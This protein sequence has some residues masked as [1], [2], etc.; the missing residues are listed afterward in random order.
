MAS[1]ASL[2]LGFTHLLLWWKTSR[3]VVYLLSAVMAFSASA[4]AMIEL[5]QMKSQSIDT[6]ATLLQWQNLAVYVL[7]LSMV[8]VL[9]ILLGTARRWL[10]IV[11]TLAWSVAIVINFNSP[12]S[13][14][15]SDIEGLR[16]IMVFG[17]DFFVQAYGPTHPWKLMV[18]IASFVILIYF[19]DAS[20]AAW[21]KGEGRRALIVGGG[22]T[23]FILFGGIHAGLVDAA[24]IASPY[25]ISFGFLAVVIAM[26]YELVS[27]AVEKTRYA[28]RVAADEERWA[29]LMENI[30]LAVIG[31][32]L[33]GRITYANPFISRLL[34]YP[35]S[36]LVGYPVVQL[37]HSDQ[38]SEFSKRLSGLPE[39]GPRDH[40]EWSLVDRTGKDHL[41]AWSSVPQKADDGR[42]IGVLSVGADI[43]QQRKA[44]TELSRSQYEMERMSRASLLGEL[45]S[46][47][48]H[49]LNQPLAAILSNTQAA[50]RLL[51]KEPLDTD[52]L[53]EI[54]DDI[55]RDNKRASDVIN[56]MRAML[57][58]DEPKRDRISLNRLIRETV[59]LVRA[60]FDRNGIMIE[61][62][63]ADGLPEVVAGVVEIQQVLINLLLNAEQAMEDMTEDRRIEITTRQQDDAVEVAVSDHGCGIPSE[64]LERAFQPLMT[65]R[66]GGIGMGLAISH[67]IIES[68]YG[69][70]K[71]ENRT[72]KGARISFALPAGGEGGES[73]D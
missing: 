37:V 30:Q 64:D 53:Q 58:K 59:G 55:V 7:L 39:S 49:E 3:A 38:I 63:L 1:A 26:S 73:H 6:Y 22:A 68:H 2:M 16:T 72:G 56:R 52:E 47:L 44:E 5:A 41:L 50:R 62:R 25:M 60:E 32:D 43:T 21:K 24:V 19:V 23:V 34:E 40:S 42:I 46:T 14:V 51:L 70:I 31:I 10:A 4:E 15:F 67:R 28:R 18:D 48:A 36:E 69:Q 33:Q 61:M 20:L 35:S 54:L 27:D 57:R 66:A 12:Y 9:Y 13:I 65:T 11:I 45:A 29:M 71:A 8:W 17:G